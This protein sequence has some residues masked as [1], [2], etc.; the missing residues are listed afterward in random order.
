MLSVCSQILHL[1]IAIG[2]AREKLHKLD[3][4]IAD[5]NRAIAL[6]PGVVGFYNNRGKAFLKKRSF[7]QRF[8]TLNM[9]LN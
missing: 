2:N 5:H 7:R 6:A 8:L 9:R 4:A 3:E 1:S